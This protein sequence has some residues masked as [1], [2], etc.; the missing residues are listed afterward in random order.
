M[1]KMP[2][3]FTF[4]NKKYKVN[5][6]NCVPGGGYVNVLT[7]YN[8]VERNGGEL[9]RLYVMCNRLSREDGRI[10]ALFYNVKTRQFDGHFTVN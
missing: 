9:I 4:N 1:R 7:Q 10:Y 8:A 3:T 5:I 6:N 2:I